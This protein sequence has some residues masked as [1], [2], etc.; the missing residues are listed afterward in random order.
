MSSFGTNVARRSALPK[1]PRSEPSK[2]RDCRGAQART[3][4]ADSNARRALSRKG[5]PCLITSATRYDSS[6][7]YRRSGK[8]LEAAP[9]TSAF[10]TTSSRRHADRARLVLRAFVR[11]PLRSQQLRTPPLGRAQFVRFAA[12][13]LRAHR[14]YLVVPQGG[15]THLVARTASWVRVNIVASLDQAFPLG[16]DYVA[17]SQP[18]PIPTSSGVKRA[19]RSA[20]GPAPER[21]CTS[22]FE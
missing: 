17:A 11:C 16:L 14:D 21:P 10:G 8:W 5:R 1:P 3:C 13:D 20:R 6:A 15:S 7:F 19:A 12:Q 9:C 22:H 2:G 4:C 18:R